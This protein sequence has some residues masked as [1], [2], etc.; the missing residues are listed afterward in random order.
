MSIAVYV[1]EYDSFID[2]LQQSLSAS[3]NDLHRWLAATVSTRMQNSSSRR[4][5]VRNL[6]ARRKSHQQI[7]SPRAKIVNDIEFQVFL[8]QF[9]PRISACK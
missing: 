2:Y 8:A 3:E 4:K 6:V 9:V 7:L 1:N 5:R